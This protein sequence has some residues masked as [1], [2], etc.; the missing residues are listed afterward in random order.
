LCREGQIK[1]HCL[2][3]SM[4]EKIQPT[5]TKATVNDAIKTMEVK[6]IR[7]ALKRNNNNRLAAARDLRIHKSTLFRKIKILGIDLPEKDGRSK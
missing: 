3:D 1:P 4:I 2:P 7:E 5:A 6:A